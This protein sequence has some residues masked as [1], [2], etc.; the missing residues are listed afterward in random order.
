MRSEKTPAH[1]TACGST[2]CSK[3]LCSSVAE[4]SF[5]SSKPLSARELIRKGGQEGWGPQNFG[6]VEPHAGLYKALESH[7]RS[8]RRPEGL[9]AAAGELAVS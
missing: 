7:T 3:L 1:R 9:P 8:A 5:R 4:V 6:R 2:C